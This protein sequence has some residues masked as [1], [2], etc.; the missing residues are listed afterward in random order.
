MRITDEGN[1]DFE[2]IAELRKFREQYP[3]EYS[4]FIV[5]RVDKAH[6]WPEGRGGAYNDDGDD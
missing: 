5:H 2:D 6:T 1:L 4:T 3:S